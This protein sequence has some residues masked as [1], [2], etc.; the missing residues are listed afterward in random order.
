MFQHTNGSAD[1]MQE[2]FVNLV[3][4]EL[5]IVL[6]Q[7]EVTIYFTKIHIADLKE[8]FR[9]DGTEPERALGEIT[10]ERLS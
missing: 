7:N 9:V 1:S 8:V 3:G 5:E 6:A 2:M 4:N 10:G